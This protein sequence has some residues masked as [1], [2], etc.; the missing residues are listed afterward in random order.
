[1]S[2]ERAERA[3]GW[4]GRIYLIAYFVA[5][6]ILKP[7]PSN[8]EIKLTVPNVWIFAAL[9]LFPPFWFF[10][11]SVSLYGEGHGKDSDYTHAQDLA[12]KMWVACSVIAAIYWFH[13]L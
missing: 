10:F 12:S 13:K 6:A 8:T 4:A 5:M 3:G 9:T 11:E 7:I 2:K 1:M